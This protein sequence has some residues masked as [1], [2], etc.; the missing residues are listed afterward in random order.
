MKLFNPAVVV[1]VNSTHPN[2]AAALEA[3][4]AAIPIL[5]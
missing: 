1:P 4:R 2:R 3:V 5:Q